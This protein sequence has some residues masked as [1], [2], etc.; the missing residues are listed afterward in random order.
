MFDNLINKIIIFFEWIIIWSMI[1]YIIIPDWYK[2]PVVKDY[3]A[4]LVIGEIGFDI[5]LRLKE[6]TTK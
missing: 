2:V 3:F 1:I 6:K 5:Y 4:L